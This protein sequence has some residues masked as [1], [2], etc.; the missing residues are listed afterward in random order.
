MSP[1]P[2]LR[3]ASGYS[4]PVIGLGVWQAYG[5]EVVEAVTIALQNGY[6]HIDTAAVYGNETEVGEGIRQSGVPRDEIFITTKIWM[7]TP[8]PWELPELSLANLGVDYIDLLLIHSPYSYELQKKTWMQM[9]KLVAD[10]KVRSIGVSNFNIHHLEKLKTWATVPISVNQIEV[11]PYN[12]RR[13][14]VEYCH[15]N[16]IVVEAYSPL[17][18][19]QK[20]TDP[21]LVQLAAEVGKTTAQVLIKWGLH[22]GFV[23]LPKSV[24]EERIKQNLDLSSWDLSSEQVAK[25]DAFD[26]YFVDGW[27]PTVYPWP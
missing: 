23:S 14:L 2:S 17:T 6:R 15:R 3:L 16:N 4:L 8:A 7:D 13:E 22:K 12:T 1:I 20:L 27:D 10:G 26:E 18:H 25:L 9:E 21:K 11:T 5:D 24:T 19:G